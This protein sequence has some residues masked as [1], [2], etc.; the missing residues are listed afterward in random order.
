MKF[1]LW[2]VPVSEERK[3]ERFFATPFN[4]YQGR[5]SPDG[6][7]VAYASDETGRFEGYVRAFP[8]GAERWQISAAGGWFPEWRRDGRE[9]YYLSSRSEIMAAQ[10]RR[11][12]SR[13][14]FGSPRRLFET[15]LP[16]LSQSLGSVNNHL[17]TVTAD[18][19]R[20]LVMAP[21]TDPAQDRIAVIV[22]WGAA[23]KY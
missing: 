1:D 9:L 8:A 23:L 22:N 16:R 7:F 13:L 12:G 19:Q 17:Y 2:T 6:R 20:F 5:F 10:V 18:G 21:V 14:V 4:E 11:A 15:T 3:I